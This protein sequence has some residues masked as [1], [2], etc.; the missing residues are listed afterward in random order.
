MSASTRAPIELV[1]MSDSFLVKSCCEAI[2][3]EGPVDQGL[4]YLE[5]RQGR[6]GP[7]PGLHQDHR[8][9]DPEAF[10]RVDSSSMSAST[11]APIELVLMSDSFLVK[12]C[13]EIKDFDISSLG[14]DD[15]AQIQAYIKIIDAT[16]LKLQSGVCSAFSRVDSSSMSAS[17]RA[18][19]ELV[20]MSDSFLVKFDIS[21]LGKDDTAQIQAYI[22][23]ID[24]TILK[25]QSGSS[26]IADAPLAPG[27]MT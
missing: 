22:K 4:R 12:S 13:C 20:L 2:R 26:S 14:K 8:R 15:T 23:I 16:I 24:A 18:P 9:D 27:V 1:L 6:H 19:I 10:S 5:P 11:R 25:L 17:T 21:S 7:D 3:V